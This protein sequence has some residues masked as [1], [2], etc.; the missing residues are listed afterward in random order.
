V[1]ANGPNKP[2]PAK[3]V[4]AFPLSP[5][6]MQL[7]WTDNPTPAFNETNFE[8]YRSDSVTGPFTLVKI[9]AA[10]IT[11]YVDVN[12]TPNKNYYYLVRAVNNFSASTNSNIALGKT[13]VDK[14][15]EMVTNRLRLNIYFLLL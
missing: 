8:V 9:T 12:L 5:S 2:S 6:T 10:D 13:S 7:D 3:N 1:N 14:A 11:S 15:K 4:T